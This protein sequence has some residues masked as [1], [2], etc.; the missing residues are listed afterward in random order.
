MT[1]TR[2]ALLPTALAMVLAIAIAAIWG[3]QITPPPP[4]DSPGRAHQCHRPQRHDRRRGNRR[5][6]ARRRLPS[7][8]RRLGQRTRSPRRP[9]RRQL[10]RSLQLRRPRPRQAN[11]HRKTPPTRHPPRLPRRR[12]HRQ[13]ALQL[14]RLD[15]PHHHGSPR[16]HPLPH[17]RPRPA[18]YP[19]GLLPHHRPPPR[20]GRVPGGE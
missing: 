9:G 10:A 19:T 14:L 16:P 5:L 7:Q 1:T 20:R 2:R 11:L 17:R 6:D 3:S 12:Q 4:R 8:P 13:R 18:P 15:N